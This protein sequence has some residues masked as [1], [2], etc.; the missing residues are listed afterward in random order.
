MAA[1]INRKE[2]VKEFFKHIKMNVGRNELSKD[3]FGTL[4]RF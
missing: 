1:Y 4:L 3:D 2:F